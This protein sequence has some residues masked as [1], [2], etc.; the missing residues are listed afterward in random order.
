MS[1][2]PDSQNG[3]PGFQIAPMVDV[4]F[5]LMLFFMACAGSQIRERELGVSLPTKGDGSVN[6]IV[7]EIAADGTVALND[8]RMGL[9]ADRMLPALRDW[10]RDAIERFGP[11]N[12]V[13][14]R[15]DP[16]VRHERLMEVLNAVSAGGVRKL[17]FG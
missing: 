10:F 9:P 11:E 15:P 4:V 6:A 7:I 12:P 17:S 8:S 1:S 2:F 3:D 5:V 13:L 14:I 16:N